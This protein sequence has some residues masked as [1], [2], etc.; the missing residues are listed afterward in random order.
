M[1]G[2][3]PD[4]TS[5]DLYAA[6]PELTREQL[7]RRAAAAIAARFPGVLAWYGPKTDRCWA[8]V[9]GAPRL[10]EASTFGALSSEVAHVR[11]ARR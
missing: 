10:L 11:V 5:A 8:Y 4:T 7:G 9:P 1:T 2:D 3:A 6:G